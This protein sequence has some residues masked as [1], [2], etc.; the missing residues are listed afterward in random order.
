MRQKPNKKEAENALLLALSSCIA[1]VTV[2]FSLLIHD[3]KTTSAPQGFRHEGISLY[4]ASDT[5]S[6]RVGNQANSS[7]ID[8]RHSSIMC[9][10]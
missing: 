10:V 5:K 4:K 2:W 1:H 7:N 3:L 6:Y 8:N 9:Y